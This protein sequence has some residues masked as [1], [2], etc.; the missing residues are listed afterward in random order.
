[1]CKESFRNNVLHLNRSYSL[2]IINRPSSIV[3]Y[4]LSII[5]YQLSQ[6]V[7][8]AITNLPLNAAALWFELVVVSLEIENRKKKKEEIK[9]TNH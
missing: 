9:K 2:S 5:N 7:C 4:Q 1:M 3:N 8:P 6:W